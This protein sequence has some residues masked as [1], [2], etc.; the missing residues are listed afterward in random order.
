MKKL[1]VAPANSTKKT[2][3]KPKV[4]ELSKAESDTSKD[5]GKEE[6]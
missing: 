2:G 1:K 3:A 4:K 6:L 5:L